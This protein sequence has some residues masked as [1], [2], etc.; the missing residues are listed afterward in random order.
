MEIALCHDENYAPYGSVVMSSVM[1][2][3]PSVDITFHILHTDLSSEKCL[4]IKYWVESHPNKSVKFYR[5]RKENFVD[6]PI[7]EHTYLD[8]G[9]YIRLFLGECLADIDKVLYL[10]CDIIVNGSLD[11]LWDTDINGYAVAGVRDR[12]NDYIRV[13][14]R[15]QYPLSDGYINSGVMLINLKKWRDDSFFDKAKTTAKMSPKILMNHDQD[16]INMIYHGQIKMLPF[17]YNLLEYYLYT[18]DWLYM[19]RKYY[20][21]IIEACKSPT[22]I[23]FCMPQKPW[24]YECINP[25]KELYYKYR[26]M[27]PWQEV[28][29]THKVQRLS[30]KQKLKLLMEKIGLYKVERKTTL[31]K[32]INIIEEPDNVLF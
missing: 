14:N 21:E 24:H 28:K 25:Y 22:I 8:Y 20:A 7:D 30:N 11:S 2:H 1:G 18:E 16:L 29:L 15:L 17:K 5:M 19:D 3:N 32:D 10:D 9:A 12:I 13:Y 6:F 4:V 27:T 23:H 26:A 31:R